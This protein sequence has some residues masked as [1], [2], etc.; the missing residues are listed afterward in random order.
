M[1]TDATRERAGNRMSARMPKISDWLVP[2]ASVLV[3]LLLAQLI[4]SVGVFR[5]DQFPTPLATWEALVAAAQTS[6]LWIAVAATLQAWFWGL[7]IATAIAMVGGALLAS[8]DFALRSVSPVIEVFKAIPAIAILPL[9]ILV[10]GSTL[11]MKIFLVAFGVL[12]PLL[13]QVIYGMRSMDATVRDTA[14]VLGV[15]GVRKF[16][17][18]TIPTAAPFVAT[19]LRIASA[20]ALILA[21]VSELVGGAVGIGRIILQAQSAGVTAYPRMYAFV[22]ISG[23]LGLILTGLFILLEKR[24]LH[25]HE[26]QRNAKTNRELSK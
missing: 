17:Q 11:S 6:T 24:A 10:L 16:L 1:T 5:P 8:N 4:T 7:L 26:S 2:V 14:R 15:R 20:N 23:L 22:I 9:V 13:I 12:W 19:G 18:V 21:V 3:V 25:W